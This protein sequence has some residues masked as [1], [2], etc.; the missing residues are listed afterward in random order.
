MRKQ[1]QDEDSSDDTKTGSMTVRE[2][3]SSMNDRTKATYEQLLL[4]N[5]N[6]EDLQWQRPRSHSLPNLLFQ[7]EDDDPFDSDEQPKRSN[8]Q[9]NLERN[10]GYEIQEYI[11]MRREI[12]KRKYRLQAGEIDLEELEDNKGRDPRD[13][14]LSKKQLVDVTG[15][16]IDETINA[17]ICDLGN[18]CWTHYHFVPKI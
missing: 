7:N 4:M 12:Q 14:E 17:K 1:K 2:D 13:V 8:Y 3:K 10:F 5:E 18:G 15:P 9:F 11:L 16:M 6:E